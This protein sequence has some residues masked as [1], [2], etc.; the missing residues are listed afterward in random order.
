MDPSLFG[1]IFLVWI[2]LSM[3]LSNGPTYKS[4]AWKYL[5]ILKESSLALIFLL[6]L[7]LVASRKNLPPHIF[8][9]EPRQST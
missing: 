4:K 3:T 7:S 9:V 5:H 8:W 2:L 1:R 6:V